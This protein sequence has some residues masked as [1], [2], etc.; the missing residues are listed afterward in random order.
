[1]CLGVLFFIRNHVPEKVEMSKQSLMRH[2]FILLI[3]AKF[4]IE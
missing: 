3:F 4:G 1:M 2:K